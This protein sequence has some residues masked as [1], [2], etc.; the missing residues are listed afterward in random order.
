MARILAVDD[1]PLVRRC[2]SR[3][4]V[5]AGHEV[6]PAGHGADALQIASDRA[7]DVALVD[8]HLPFIDGLEVLQRLR[9]VQPG[10]LRILVTGALDLPMLNPM[11]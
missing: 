9:E 8:F 5:N 7:F 3:I 6:V 4:L 2:I 10:C 11:N 1:D